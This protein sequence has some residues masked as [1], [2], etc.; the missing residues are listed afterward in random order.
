MKKRKTK[1]NSESEINNVS[2]GSLIWIL[3]DFDDDHSELEGY[4]EEKE[5]PKLK[6]RFSLSSLFGSKSEA[7]GIDYSNQDNNT[8]MTDPMVEND[9]TAEDQNGGSENG[10]N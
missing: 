8:D 6:K 3:E 7:S 2:N 10:G 9:Q 5:T 1:I 4:V